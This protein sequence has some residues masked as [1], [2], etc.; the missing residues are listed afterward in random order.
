M[1]LR[2]REVTGDKKGRR[3]FL[4]LPDVINAD[5][6]HWVTPLRDEMSKLIDPKKN[7]ALKH[8]DHALFLAERNGRPV[9]RISAHVDHRHNQTHGE[10]T[11]MFGFFDCHEDE[12]A[13]AALVDTAREWV[14]QRGMTHLRGPNSW[15]MH[16]YTGCLVD[17]FGAPPA[18]LMNHNPPYYDGLLKGAGLGKK[19][20]LFAWRFQ[21]DTFPETVYDFYQQAM[22]HE[23]LTFRDVDKKDFD[24]D[25]RIVF[26]V[27]NA[28][29]ADNWGFYP[30]SEEEIQAAAGD[31]KLI[32]DPEL[33][34]IVEVKGEPAAVC[35]CVPNI[36]EGLKGL[37][38]KL[39]PFGWAK[40]LWRLKVK[41]LRSARLM[42]LGIKP[43]HRGELSA[44]MLMGMY[45]LLNE[46]AMAKGIEWG[47][48][49]WTLENNDAINQSISLTNAEQYKTYRIYETEV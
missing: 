36:T 39:L 4:D 47:E 40:L 34:Y 32:F 18:I 8:M 31:L 29:W 26:D 2:I 3:A 46:R 23:E 9:G 44:H 14:K 33:S 25:L 12:A 45:G 48:L 24:R 10:T 1:T 43:E 19:M 27:F 49:S 35:V 16:E 30:I 11:G 21:A 42:I 17:G 22:E 41:G 15:S 7:P 5:D 13:A 20:D 38:G 6:P 28:A 37:K